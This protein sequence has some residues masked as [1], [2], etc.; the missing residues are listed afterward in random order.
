MVSPKLTGNFGPINGDEAP[1]DTRYVYIMRMTEHAIPKM[2]SME[3]A[4]TEMPNFFLVGSYETNFLQSMEHM[5][6]KVDQNY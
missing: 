5:L 1:P 4:K 6:R 2:G 3:Y